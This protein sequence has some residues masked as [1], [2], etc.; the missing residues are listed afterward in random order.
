M[1]MY[2][3]VALRLAGILVTATHH[4]SPLIMICVQI[5]HVLV[6]FFFFFKEPVRLR[7]FGSLS[8]YLSIYLPPLHTTYNT[9]IQYTDYNKVIFFFFFFHFIL[10]LTKM[11]DTCKKL[12]LLPPKQTNKQEK[13]ISKVTLDFDC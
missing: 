1:Y 3:L 2:I 4:H 13:E 6:Y 5:L 10:V 11:K 9:H 12:P 8:I 7:Y